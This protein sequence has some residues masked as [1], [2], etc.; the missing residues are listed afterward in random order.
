MPPHSQPIIP[1]APYV[2]AKDLPGW[3]LLLE[4][5]RNTVSTMPDYAFDVLISRR[6]VFGL[7]SL[8]VSDPDGVRHVLATAAAKYTRLMA[9]YRVFRPLGGDGVFLAEGAEWRRQRRMLAS[10]FM[11]TSVGLLLPH[12]TEAAGDLVRQIEDRP[13]ANLSAAFQEATLEAVLRALFS[14]PDSSQR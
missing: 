1:P 4:F 7:D 10:L 2:H 9:F 8:L 11:P 6:R 3:R 12:F 13:E 14:L 5:N